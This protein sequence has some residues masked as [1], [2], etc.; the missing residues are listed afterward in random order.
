MGTNGTPD[1]SRRSFDRVFRGGA[2]RQEVFEEE[3]REI[4]AAVKTGLLI[5]GKRLLSHGS[6]GRVA[7]ASD[8][9]VAKSFQDQ[10]RDLA[11]RSRQSPPVELHVDFFA[12]AA[13]NLA[14]PASF[15]FRDRSRL[16]ELA[17]ERELALVSRSPR[18][19]EPTRAYRE[20]QHDGNAN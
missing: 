16:V 7:G 10:Q 13:Q 18:S 15:V 11:F 5:D 19:E 20:C 3:G 14:R 6:L 2:P 17:G 8:F 1:D 12:K 4:G 9:L